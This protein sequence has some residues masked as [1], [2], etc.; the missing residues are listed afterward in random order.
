MNVHP[1]LLAKLRALHAIF[2]EQ[3]RQVPLY[4]FPNFSSFSEP[5]MANNNTQATDILKDFL[6]D[7]ETGGDGDDS[8]G[9]TIKGL[10]V[11]KT[12]NTEHQKSNQF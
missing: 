1:L 6:T 8:S 10:R 9:G 11:E 3:W 5:I 12:T 7:E 4:R 2:F